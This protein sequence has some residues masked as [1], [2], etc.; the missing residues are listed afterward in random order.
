MEIE[1]KDFTF[2]HLKQIAEIVPKLFEIQYKFH[3][4]KFVITFLAELDN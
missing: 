3:L 4:H 1:S 2:V